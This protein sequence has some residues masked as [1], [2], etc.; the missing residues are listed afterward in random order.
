MSQTQG[1]GYGASR[2]RVSARG[3]RTLKASLFTQIVNPATRLLSG[4]QP[5]TGPSGGPS[6]RGPARCTRKPRRS[7]FPGGLSILPLGG[8]W[9]PPLGHWPR[10]CS[11]RP[12]T[13]PECRQLLPWPAR[14][15]FQSS[16]RLPIRSI[17]C[18]QELAACP[19]QLQTLLS[20][21][22]LFGAIPSPPPHLP[23]RPLHPKVCSFRRELTC[24]LVKSLRMNL[25]GL[26]TWRLPGWTRGRSAS[27]AERVGSAAPCR[28]WSVY[29][30]AE[31]RLRSVPES[32]TLQRRPAEKGCFALL[33]VGAGS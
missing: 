29:A 15:V 22:F 21:S 16:F 19:Y 32:S 33:W 3:M 24:L 12:V 18:P 11:R 25:T 1:A 14:P 5:A 26:V 13:L 7:A 30:V 9:L 17:N 8:P 6:A 20:N 23:S 27:A 2:P 10:G 28:P 31:Q 4:T